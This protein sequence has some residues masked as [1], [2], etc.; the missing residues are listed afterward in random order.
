MTVESQQA[1]T[2]ARKSPSGAGRRIQYLMRERQ[3]LSAAGLGRH[4][5]LPATTLQHILAGNGVSAASAR[6]LAAWDSEWTADRYVAESPDTQLAR[7]TKARAGAILAAMRWYLEKHSDDLAATLVKDLETKRGVASIVRSFYRD[8]E[9]RDL[10]LVLGHY[11][12][13]DRKKRRPFSIESRY[14]AYLMRLYM[15]AT[16]GQPLPTFARLMAPDPHVKNRIP[17]ELR[18]PT[19]FAVLC[20]IVELLHKQWTQVQIAKHFGFTIHAGH[21]RM[22]S[23]LLTVA[24]R[25]NH[26]GR[27]GRWEKPWRRARWHGALTDADLYLKKVLPE[28]SRS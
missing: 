15:T 12:F 18:S 21:S 25:L 13:R 16:V 7:T 8:P 20:A 3:V 4:V 1:K 2:L 10:R 5:G 19:G 11:N 22:V 14:R 23:V 6:R 17:E 28:E 27:D 24:A 26:G 9:Y